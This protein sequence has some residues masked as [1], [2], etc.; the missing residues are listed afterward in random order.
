[1]VK[2]HIS[3]HITKP[4]RTGESESV[5]ETDEG[6]S[7]PVIR[8]KKIYTLW[9]AASS[10]NVFQAAC[11]D[12]VQGTVPGLGCNVT[13]RQVLTST[14]E[15]FCCRPGLYR[16]AVLVSFVSEVPIS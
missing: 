10:L 7:H 2:L 13:Q 9:S 16:L 14:A 12:S 11:T 1:M 15:M 8:R 4:G 3:K 5:Y 6:F